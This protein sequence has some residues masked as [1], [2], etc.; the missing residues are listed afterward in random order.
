MVP[1][2]KSNQSLMCKL[3]KRVDAHIDSSDEDLSKFKFLAH[4]RHSTGVIGTQHTWSDDPKINELW[5]QLSAVKIE[6]TQD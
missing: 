6:S 1:P 2:I 3:G 5:E 4:L